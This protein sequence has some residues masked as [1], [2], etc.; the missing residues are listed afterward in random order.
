MKKKSKTKISETTLEELKQLFPSCISE[1]KVNFEKLR[2][3]LGENIVLN[4]E[5]YEL[6]W[7][8]RNKTFDQITE[9]VTGKLVSQKSKSVN[10]SKT[11]NMLIDGD[12][13]EVLK[14]LR[15]N[16][17]GKIKMIYIDPPYNTGK[18]RQYSD[19][20]T[21]N[22]DI[23]DTIKNPKNE[24]ELT[25][26]AWISMIYA[27]LHVAR[28]L[29]SDD[30]VIFVSIGISESFNLRRVMNDIFGEDNF[31]TEIVW[32]SKYTISNDKKFISNQHEYVMAFAKNYNIANFN[33][34]PRTKKANK[35][36]TN[37]DNDPRGPWKATPLH[38][39][40]GKKNSSFIFKNIKTYDGKKVKPI[41]W[42]APVGRFPRYNEE[43]L[44]RLDKDNRITCGADGTFTPQ[45]KSFLNEVKQGITPGSLWK[46]DD[47]GHT[48]FANEELASLLGKGVFDNPKPTKLIKKMIHLSTETRNEDIILDFFAGS[49]TTAHAV[50]EKNKEDGGNRIFICVQ[51]PQKN[52]RGKYKTISDISRE[53]IMKVIKKIQNE[54]NLN[55]F[56]MDLGFKFY[57]L[58]FKK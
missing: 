29:L 20:F 26:S 15:K 9:S 13:L 10:S 39:K 32:N 45:V 57:K 38:A 27:R 19:N 53:R 31:I 44:Q 43:S 12:N 52:E 24:T 22:Q 18:E 16:Y 17:E 2:K 30:G 11:Q 47:V 36:Y 21:I 34:L 54:S 8:G 1:K 4:S 41:T 14:I 51:D 40:S 55:K 5:S 35:A 6:N 23:L 28:E 49:G 7:F 48:H 37:P 42:T 3:L 56:N 25:H 58:K 46:Y 33:L 50:L